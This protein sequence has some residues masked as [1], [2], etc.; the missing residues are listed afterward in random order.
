MDFKEFQ[1]KMS[2]YLDG[3]MTAEE[4]RL[5]IDYA[6]GEPKAK[7]LLK[8][9]ECILQEVSKLPKE[10]TLPKPI[11]Y[12]EDKVVLLPK[13]SKKQPSIALRRILPMAA[14]FLLMVGTFLVYDPLVE[15]PREEDEP[16]VISE[17]DQRSLINTGD[18]SL[19]PIV[20][21]MAEDDGMVPHLED[22]YVLLVEVES[23]NGLQD[24]LQ[25][26]AIDSTEQNGMLMIERRE[27][28]LERIKEILQQSNISS[29]IHQEEENYKTIYLIQ[30]K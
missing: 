14:A 23:I 6:E 28:L 24:T 18:E 12:V 9:M 22:G 25:L 21:P 15:S 20:N 8:D 16:S 1:N 4:R 26:S 27:G 29:S 2:A 3:E 10:I 17:G 7:A 13:K 11:Q 30:S 5:F 19:G